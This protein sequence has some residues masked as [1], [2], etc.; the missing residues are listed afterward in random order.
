METRQIPVVSSEEFR[1]LAEHNPN[2]LHDNPWVVEGHIENWPGYRQWQDLDYLRNRFGGL[3][4][5]AKAPNFV[6]NKNSNLV[7]VETSFEQYLRYIEHPDA[8]QEIYKDCWLEGDY[9][10]YRDLGLPLYCGTLR[11]VHQANDPVLDEFSPMLPEPLRAWNHALPYYYTLFNHFWL[12][13]SLPGALTPLHTDNN[14]TIATIAQ[15]KGR[16]RA[17]LYSP[18]DLRHV[19]NPQ[20]GFLDPD[21]PDERDFPTW[22]RAVK[23]VADLDV[24]QVLFVGTNWAHHVKTLETSISVSFDFVEQ[25]NLAA[26]ATSA[27]WAAALGDR[28]K[29]RPDMIVEKMRGQMTRHDIETLPAATVGRCVMAH[30]LRSTLASGDSPELAAVRRQYLAHLEECLASDRDVAA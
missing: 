9:E 16:K 4:A 23:W 17:T 14:G 3:Q 27:Q 2:I 1:R 29:R 13:V 28:S 8:V 11:I 30:I 24:G 26:Y 7:S 18:A 12:L 25:S 6:T 10:Q 5:F 19:R 20:V 21:A 15:L 22:D